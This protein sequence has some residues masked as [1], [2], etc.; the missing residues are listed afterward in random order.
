MIRQCPT[1]STEFFQGSKC[2]INKNQQ[3]H[4]VC[5]KNRFHNNP[6]LQIN[7][8]QVREWGKGGESPVNIKLCNFSQ[9]I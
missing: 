8:L 4:L 6:D 7:V 5:A 1:S 3:T 9:N 2:L